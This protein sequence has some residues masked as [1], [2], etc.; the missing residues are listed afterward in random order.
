M[1]D[2]KR[3]IVNPKEVGI[4]VKGKLNFDPFDQICELIERI[5]DWV[6]IR[7]PWWHT[8]AQTFR[9]RPSQR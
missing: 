9:W 4:K 7:T 3:A 8:S 5:L 2:V 1:K 6:R